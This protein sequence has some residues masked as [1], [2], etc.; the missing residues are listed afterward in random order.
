MKKLIIEARINEYQSR[1]VN[2][3]VPWTAEEIGEDADED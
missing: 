3:H 2:A 1:A